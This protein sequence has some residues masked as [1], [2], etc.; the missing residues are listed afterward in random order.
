MLADA[1]SPLPPILVHRDTMRVI[2]GAHRLAAARLQGRTVIEVRFFDGSA[3]DAFRLGVVANVVH[4]L[5]LSLADRRRAAARLIATH[6]QLSDRAIARSAGLSPKTVASIRDKADE[7]RE[8]AAKSRRVGI[9]GRT[10]PLNP[11]DRRLVA[12]SLV[13]RRPEASLRELAQ[14]AGIS[15]STARDV[16]NRVLAGED[17]VP[18]RLQMAREAGTF[19]PEPALS[20][21]DAHMNRLRRD[22]A[23]R[24]SDS[25]RALLR[26]LDAGMAAL[27]QLQ[28]LAAP[29]VPPH[30]EAT[31][32]LVVRAYAQGWSQIADGLAPVAPDS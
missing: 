4:G 10:R 11:A 15:V 30:C 7:T 14:E 26:W 6:P 13:Q 1:G 28:T 31:V 23:L 19:S 22:P 2:D 21:I 24:Y 25:G 12:S 5:P 9:D 16:R 29:G 32:A 3:E 27:G 18:R 17:P 20:D 8:P